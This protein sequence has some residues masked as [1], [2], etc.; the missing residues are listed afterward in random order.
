MNKLQVIKGQKTV[1]K[2]KTFHKS[3]KS[4]K[5]IYCPILKD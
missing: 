4:S 5:V 2:I 1:T 3:L